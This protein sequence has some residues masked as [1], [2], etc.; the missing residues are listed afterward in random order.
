MI[1]ARLLVLLCASTLAASSGADPSSA[2]IFDTAVLAELNRARTQPATYIK[3]LKALR[4]TYNQQGQYRNL[5][6]GQLMASREG[7]AAVD[8]AIAVLASLS[9]RPA[10][11]ASPLL[12]AAA[13][14][15]TAVQ[16]PRGGFGHR[17]P[18]GSWPSD[19]L[20]RRGGGTFV[21]E[22]ISYGP[23]D[24]R[25]VILQLL[26][27]DGVSGRGHRATLLKRDYNHAGAACGPHSRYGLMC[28]ITLSD[29][30][31]GK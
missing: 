1:G 18:R 7:V 21:A 29:S 27:D 22:A 28:T 10:L 9:P 20:K 31:S 17:G 2:L 6:D 13:A 15:H 24:P 12:A 14:D 5:S 25:D 4:A 26:V 30:P 11:K 8:E 16:G 3:D 23:G 19:R